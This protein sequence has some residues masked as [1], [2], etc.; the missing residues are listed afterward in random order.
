MV[1]L[2]LKYI[3]ESYSKN[4]RKKYRIIND[5]PFIISNFNNK[6]TKLDYDT[7]NIILRCIYYDFIKENKKRLHDK[8]NEYLEKCKIKVNSNN[9]NKYTEKTD[10]IF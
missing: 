7:Q 3:F 5:Y 2:F 9:I 1:S 10:D 6:L 8:F 4:I